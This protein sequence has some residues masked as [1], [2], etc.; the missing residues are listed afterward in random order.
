MT[1]KRSPKVTQV[2]LPWFLDWRTM[3]KVEAIL[4]HY[5]HMRLRFYFDK[6]GCIRCN[7]KRVLYCANGLC[8]PCTGLVRDRMEQSDKK[9][10]RRYGKRPEI[11]SAVILKRMKTAQELLRD[12]RTDYSAS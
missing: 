11:P 4:P 8:K 1:E 10:K 6:Y 12:F 7:R 2:F 3:K 5:Y 9:M